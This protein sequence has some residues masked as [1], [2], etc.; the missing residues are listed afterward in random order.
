MTKF[1]LLL[2]GG[3]GSIGRSLI[4]NIQEFDSLLIIDKK[5]ITKPSNN[6]VQCELE[7]INDLQKIIPNIPD[8]L[9]VVYL[10]GNLSNSFLPQDI[11]KSI[12]DNL[13]GLSNFI[14]LFH[15]KIKNFIYVS[16][17]SVYGIPQYIPIDEN[18]STYPISFYGCMKKCGEIISSTL[19]KNFKI[20]LT[21]IRSTQLYGLDSA[22]NSLP[23]LLVNYLKN[24]KILKINS[25]PEYVRDY[26]HIFDFCT[27]MKKL[28]LNP[29]P[30]IFNLGTGHGISIL[31]LF[32]ISYEF[33]QKKFE[34]NNI[35]E[36]DLKS[37]YSQ[38]LDITKI[39]N[40]FNFQPNKN[41]IDWLKNEL[42][43]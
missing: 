16:S 10:A 17:V 31:D 21:I 8:N 20:P 7:N 3:M 30:G 34:L 2:V 22:L 19:C 36:T 15:T 4:N 27:F 40:E 18:H 38:V 26:L 28:I 9:V 25:N 14:T 1:N 32:K 41:I 29:K 5:K 43:N 23:H 13:M 12:Q 24:E 39:K 37:S 35:L 6:Y 11:S 33:T 42:I